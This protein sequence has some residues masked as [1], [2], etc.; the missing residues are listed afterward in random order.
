[1]KAKEYESLPDG[2]IALAK[3]MSGHWFA[4]HG[5][6]IL[7]GVVSIIVLLFFLF[8]WNQRFSGG[9][10]DYL[11]VD[12]AFSNWFNQEKHDSMLFKQVKEPLERHPELAAKFGGLIAQRLLTLGESN[13]ARGFAESVLKR[14]KNVLS[15]PYHSLFS[16]N[17]LMISQGCFKEALSASHQ[18]KLCME[19]DEALWTPSIV[20][21]GRILYAYNLLRIA[22]LE[23]QAG[24]PEGE[25]AAWDEILQNIDGSARSVSSKRMDADAFKM[26]SEHLHSGDA[27]LLG[28]IQQRKRELQQNKTIK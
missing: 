2:R 6:K 21:A 22:A 13:L 25:S 4:A 7:Y 5:N 1:M 18:L 28:F 26:I 3:L 8:F 12:A 19:V 14:T 10:S 27:S 11:K 16:E 24:S 23:R 9:R 20:N 15:C 17:T